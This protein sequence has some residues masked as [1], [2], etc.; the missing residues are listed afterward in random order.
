LID[1]KIVVL[2]KVCCHL[3]S[4]VDDFATMGLGVP[5]HIMMNTQEPDGSFPVKRLEFIALVSNAPGY[6]G[7]ETLSV[8]TFGLRFEVVGAAVSAA[9]RTPLEETTSGEFVT[10]RNHIFVIRLDIVSRVARQIFEIL[11][12]SQDCLG[13]ELWQPWSL[14][15]AGFC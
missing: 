2:V 1:P 6:P 4:G 8:L 10:G 3:N 9:S 14:S 13:D 15:F 5:P 7:L 11:S 12:F